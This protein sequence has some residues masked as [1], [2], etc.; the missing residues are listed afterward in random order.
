MFPTPSLPI[1][2]FSITPDQIPILRSFVPSAVVKHFENPLTQNGFLAELR[3]VTVMFV[4]LALSFREDKVPEFQAVVQ[5]MFSNVEESEGMIRQF[6]IDDKGSV[7][8]AGFGLPPLSHLDDPTRAVICALKIHNELAQSGVSCSIGI[9]TGN[10]FCGC[11]GSF[12]RRE[13][14]IVGDSIQF[15]FM[16]IILP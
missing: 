9:T 2:T 6:L 10:A 14:A 3:E 8:I 12:R 16:K 1:P 5:K 11:V 4:N 15:I 7:F 13:Y